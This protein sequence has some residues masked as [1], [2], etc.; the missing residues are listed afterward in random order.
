MGCWTACA[1]GRH[2]LVPHLGLPV[3]NASTASLGV[4]NSV[5]PRPRVRN[6]TA[7]IHLALIGFEAQRQM[8]IGRF[9]LGQRW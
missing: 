5:C 6:C 7:R 2:P 4:K 1:D 3:L 9:K 8:P